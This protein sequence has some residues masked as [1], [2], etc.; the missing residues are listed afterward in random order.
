MTKKKTKKKR[1]K[2]RTKPN[3]KPLA[4]LTADT[5][6]HPVTW[7]SRPTLRDDAFFAFSQLFQYCHD[8]SVKYMV[9]AGDV[10]E[11]KINDAVTPGFIRQSMEY[12]ESRKIRVFFV[13]GQHDLQ[14]SSEPWLSSISGWPIHLA[15]KTMPLYDF[16]MYGL[17]WTP[18]SQ[19]E[20]ALATI[21]E[22]TDILVMHQVCTEF[23]GGVRECEL[24]IATVPHAKVIL[25][26]DYHVHEKRKLRMTDGRTALVLSPG[27]TCVQ[28]IHEEPA[29]QFFVLYEDMSVES[30]PLRGRH[31]L[32]ARELLTHEAVDDFVE[33]VEGAI[34]EAVEVAANEGL[35]EVLQKPIL[36]VEYADDLEGAARRVRRAVGNDAFLFEKQLVSEPSEEEGKVM[37]GKKARQVMEKAGLSGFL[38]RV[39]DRK[40][41]KKLFMFCQELLD[42]NTP[43]RVLAD[44]RAKFGLEQEEED[45]A[46]LAEA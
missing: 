31:V 27:S 9:V 29:K 37:S 19:I 18:P 7:S 21:P 10:L 35:P 20:E 33:G 6:L 11:R 5:H 3:P 38:P 8:H 36:R 34:E 25:M 46:E 44:W 43:L 40:K 41:E 4:V 42:S 2:P 45:D 16:K 32:S 24:T 17:D 23:M 30:M 28:K 26:G 1:P 14:L 22:D 15:R 12:A 13:Q 39:L